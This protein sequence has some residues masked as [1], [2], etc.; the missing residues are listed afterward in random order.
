[1]IRQSAGGSH[2]RRMGDSGNCP[3]AGTGTRE[4]IS[5]GRGTAR[6]DW[7]PNPVVVLKQLG[8]DLWS[9]RF[10]LTVS[11]ALTGATAGAQTVVI[12]REHHA[13]GRFPPG[14]WSKVRKWMEELDEKGNVKSASTTETKTTLIGVDEGGCTLQMEVTVEV[15]G[16][17]FVAQPRQVRVEFDGGNASQ[18]AGLHKVGEKAWDLGGKPVPC[19][20]LESVVTNDETRVT[21]KLEYCDSMPPFVLR[22]ETVTA[23]PDGKQ[24]LE[25]TVM[26]VI[27]VEMPQKVLTEL[28]TGAHMRTVQRQKSGSTFTLEVVCFDVPGGVVSH[29]SKDLNPAGKLV[30]RSTL[31]LIDYGVADTSDATRRSGGVFYHGRMRRQLLQSRP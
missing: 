4:S 17:R 15:A 12:P 23:T 1:M 27:A 7:Y 6:N 9:I 25:Q 14:S 16:K 5:A 3:A 29:T 2:D 26:E 20:A 10:V 13:W 21:S 11:L 19:A 24:V 18:R 30:R 28:K 31:E 22:R 8:R